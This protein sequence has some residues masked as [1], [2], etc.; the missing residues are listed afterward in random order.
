MGCPFYEICAKKIEDLP[1][2]NNSDPACFG[3]D[4]A[5]WS[6]CIIYLDLAKDEA[7]RQETSV[8]KEG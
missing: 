1:G 7:E 5:D 2:F 4:L 8:H 3:N 6:E